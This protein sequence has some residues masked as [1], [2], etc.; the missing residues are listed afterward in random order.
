MV[1]KLSGLLYI[2]YLDF[3]GCCKQSILVLE[4]VIIVLY[5]STI[6]VAVTH[7]NCGFLLSTKG[8][9]AYV[10]ALLVAQQTPTSSTVNLKRFK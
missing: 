5:F 9:C 7:S 2:V 3:R 4:D 10:L 6:T 8:Q 1:F